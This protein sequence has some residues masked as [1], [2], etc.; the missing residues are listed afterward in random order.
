MI[1]V[2]LILFQTDPRLIMFAQNIC[3]LI[4]LLL[5]AVA[6]LAF[7][8]ATWTGANIFFWKSAQ[9]QAAIQA[10]NAKYDAVGNPLPPTSRGICESCQ[11]VSENVLHFPGGARICRSC[12]DAGQPM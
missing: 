7:L 8:I 11:R 9:K 4:F 3:L 10:R 1:Q 5:F 2:E 12:Y 6:G